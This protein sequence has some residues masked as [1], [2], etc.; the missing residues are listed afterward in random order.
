MSKEDIQN[1]VSLLVPEFQN[2]VSGIMNLIV[3]KNWMPFAI[4]ETLRTQER[5]NWLFAQGYS[6]TLT[7]NHSTG[8]AIDLV[9]FIDGKWSWADKHIPLYKTMIVLVKDKYG[10]KVRC[11]GVDFGAFKDYPHIEMK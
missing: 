3:V 4:F 6:K 10:D 8:R 7:S 11:G 1:D 2:I 5:Q 9:V